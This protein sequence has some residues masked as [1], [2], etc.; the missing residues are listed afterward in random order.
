MLL[1]Y[2]GLFLEASWA[3]SNTINMKHKAHCNCQ[4]GKFM[5]SFAQEGTGQFQQAPQLGLPNEISFMHLH[6]HPS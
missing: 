5:T 3:I 6:K 2:Q 1:T 4:G